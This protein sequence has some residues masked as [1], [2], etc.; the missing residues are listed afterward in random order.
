MQHDA[1]DILG[2]QLPG[3]V[4]IEAVV[5]RQRGDH[6]EVI[7]IAAIPAAHRAR[8]Q[9][10]LRMADYPR[11]VEELGH[12]QPVASR[13]R[14]HRRVEREQPRFQL[15]Q[16]VVAHGAGILRR[17]Q[18]GLAFGLI[19]RLHDGHA[20]AELER[21]LEG[22]G[23]ALL[24][25]GTRLEAIDHRLDGVLLAQ[26]QR[27]HRVDF[28]HMAVDAHARVALRAQLLEHLQV[29]ALAFA[30]HGCQ[31]HPAL[32]GERLVGLHRQHLVDHLADGLRLQREVV[33]RAARSADARVQQAQVVV[34]LGDRADR[35]T[36]VVAGGFL[37]DRDRRAQ[38][39]DVVDVGL[40]HHAQELARVRRQRFDV[41]TLAF[42]IDRVER[43]RRLAG[44]GQAGDHDQLVAR[45]VEVDVLEVVRPCAA[46][47]DG[48]QRH[49]WGILGKGS[50]RGADA[51]RRAIQQR[52][53]PVIWGQMTG[54]PV[55]FWWVSWTA[56]QA[57]RAEGHGPA[58][59]S[60]RPGLM[61]RARAI[62]GPL[63]PMPPAHVATESFRCFK[64][65]EVS[66]FRS[67][68]VM[69]P[70]WKSSPGRW[71]LRRAGHGW[72][73]TAT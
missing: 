9:R 67:Y 51:V 47:A 50:G 60:S 34:D 18:Q 45:Q 22:L 61:R 66:R 43:Q 54:L 63:G 55:W 44:A 13:A 23:Q 46:N 5:L 35:R 3:Q 15:R 32:A 29:L 59:L 14:T 72:P 30:H 41:A 39:L 33:V 31:Q 11:G 25:L 40:V 69:P 58:A 2:Q 7:G 24:D 16:R 27:R 62:H 57:P 21:G 73:A 10:Q 52:T 20:V 4:D 8:R 37:L 17:E 26:S 28:V 71:G 38:A 49:G 64:K 70:S 42:G 19:H 68:T 6:R 65:R 1:A 53:E 36:R 56:T 48:V 12:A